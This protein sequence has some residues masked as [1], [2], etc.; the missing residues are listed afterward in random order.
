M[1]RGMWRR[2]GLSSMEEIEGSLTG[3]SWLVFWRLGSG[4]FASSEAGSEGASAGRPSGWWASLR[5]AWVSPSDLCASVLRRI[6]EWFAEATFGSWYQTK[7]AAF[8]EAA[9]WRLRVIW[10][11]PEPGRGSRLT[12]NPARLAWKAPRRRPTVVAAA[13]AGPFPYEAG[14]SSFPSG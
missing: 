1:I 5:H 11:R 8:C 2:W 3:W 7:T 9:V 6:L 10:P 14:F 13:G 12:G 4:V